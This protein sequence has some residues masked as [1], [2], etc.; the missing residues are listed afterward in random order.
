MSDPVHIA[1]ID[2]GSNALR[3]AV[4]RAFSALDIEPLVN[5]RSLRL[6]LEAG[7]TMPRASVARL[8]P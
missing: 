1:A 4:A 6:P 2:A 5:E 8:R 3:L 7:A